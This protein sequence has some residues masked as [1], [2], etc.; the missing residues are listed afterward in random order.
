MSPVSLESCCTTSTKKPPAC[1]TCEKGGLG[2][3]KGQLLLLPLVDAIFL[4]EW[5]QRG[6]G[7]LNR[8]GGSDASWFC[9]CRARPGSQNR[10]IID[11]FFF[12]QFP[13]SLF[14]FSYHCTSTCLTPLTPAA[15]LCG[16]FDSKTSSLKGFQSSC[17]YTVH[18]CHN[19]PPPSVPKVFLLLTETCFRL[20]RGPPGGGGGVDYR[21]GGCKSTSCRLEKPRGHDFFRRCR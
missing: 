9:F 16:C 20:R 14:L 4:P 18:F 6:C 10:P 13:F 3:R 1:Y 15:S 19:S 12:F 8:G 21:D 5:R 11:F 17:H 2:E 7:L